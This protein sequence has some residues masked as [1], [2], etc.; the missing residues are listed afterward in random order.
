VTD[1]KTHQ[2][3]EQWWEVMTT[4]G[5]TLVLPAPSKN[6]DIVGLLVSGK[7]YVSSRSEITDRTYVLNVDHVLM[8]KQ[9]TVRADV[10]RHERSVARLLGISSGPASSDGQDL[11]SPSD[12]TANRGGRSTGGPI[13]RNILH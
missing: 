4:A 13:K 5:L 3:E 2:T 9:Y 6:T 8:I 11:A 1:P 12:T 10:N 7:Q